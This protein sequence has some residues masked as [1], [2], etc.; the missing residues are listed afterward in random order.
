MTYI[1]RQN[2]RLYIDQSQYFADTEYGFHAELEEK[3]EVDLPALKKTKLNSGMRN[4]VT[5][6]S[7][8]FSPMYLI[9]IIIKRR[10]LTRFLLCH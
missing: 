5:Q 2:L 7:Y 8:F 10:R 3:V 4:K 9:I 1:S 6:S